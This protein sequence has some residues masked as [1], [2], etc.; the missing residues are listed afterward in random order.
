SAIA[1]AT[2]ALSV[3]YSYHFKNTVLLGNAAVAV[4]DATIVLFGAAAVGYV[5]PVILLLSSIMALY[6][7]AEEILFTLKDCEGDQRAGVRTI[8]TRWGVPASLWVYRVVVVVFLASAPIP[9]ILG[10][11]T[12]WYLVAIVY[13]SMLPVVAIAT[14][15]SLSPTER[16][17]EQ[18]AHWMKL[19]WISSLL[20]VLL[21]R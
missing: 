10:L 9:V 3:L 7:L 20:P 12:P 19:I 2:L 1:L 17:F 13:C 16:R 15:I 5:R 11:A 14:A 8:A 21:L 6:A 4:L 18:G